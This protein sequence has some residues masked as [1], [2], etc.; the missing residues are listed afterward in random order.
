LRDQGAGLDGNETPVDP[1]E[2]VSRLAAAPDLA[3]ALAALAPR[4]P[5]YERLRRTL[6]ELRQV[7]AGGGWTRVPEGETLD[8]G[9]RNPRV[10]L[11]RER[12]AGRDPAVETPAG[13]AVGASS[14]GAAGA[15]KSDPAHFDQAL[16]RAV[17][18]FQQRSGLAVDGRVGPKTLAALNRTA[19]ELV[20]VVQ[21]N[22]ERWRWL[23]QDLGPRYLLVNTAGYDLRVVEDGEVVLRMPVVTGTPAR[24]TPMFS[25]EMSYL[26]VNPTWTVPPTI[27]AEDY[28]PELREDPGYLARQRITLYASWSESAVPIDPYSI[29]WHA[30]RASPRSLPYRLV[31]SPGPHNAL[32]RIKFMMPNRH[33][34]YL[35]DTNH[36]ELFS[37]SRRALSSGCV[38]LARPDDLAKLVLKDAEGWDMERLQALYASGESDRISLQRSWPVHMVYFTV[39][40][41]G[42]GTTHFYDDVYGRDRALVEQLRSSEVLLAEEPLGRTGRS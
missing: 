32:G 35:H 23:P 21:A 37:R 38:R 27:F 3:A 14:V 29:D 4:H 28:L 10:V 1:V 39:W 19:A 9:M 6:A 11:L 18:S 17:R 7:A 42:D 31:Q 15:D 22:M 16:E 36:P 20:E 24:A 26:E 12:L 33:T 25:A 40:V 30:V 8:P 5:Q 2:A 34:I 13:E 41:D